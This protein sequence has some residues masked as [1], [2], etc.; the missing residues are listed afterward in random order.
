MFY[1]INRI[2]YFIFVIFLIS[3]S[4]FASGQK[5]LNTSDYKT[6]VRIKMLIDENPA[7]YLD[8]PISVELEKI[9]KASKVYIYLSEIEADKELIRLAANELLLAVDEMKKK[10]YNPNIPIVVKPNIRYHYFSSGKD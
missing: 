9:H 6:A 1:K 4:N 5:S 2:S 7:L 8:E 3:I 10:R